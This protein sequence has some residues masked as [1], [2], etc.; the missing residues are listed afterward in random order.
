LKRQEAITVGVGLSARGAIEL[1]MIR[2]AYEAGL[3]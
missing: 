2:I 1:V 3:F